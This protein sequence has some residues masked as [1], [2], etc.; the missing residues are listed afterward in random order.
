[1]HDS[2]S[3]VPG[4]D[5]RPRCLV[6]IR[7]DL[8]DCTRAADSW[9]KAPAD[10]APVTRVTPR[11]A[12]AASRAHAGNQPRAAVSTTGQAARRGLA[13]PT[14]PLEDARA[15]GQ[16]ILRDG[17]RAGDVRQRVRALVT[18]TGPQHAGL[19]RHD[20]MQ[21]GRTRASREVARPRVSR[22]PDLAAGLPPVRGDRIP[23]PPVLL[24]LVIHGLEAMRAVADR[25]RA[26]LIRSGTPAPP[27]IVVAVRDAGSGLDAQTVDRICDAFLTT[28]P[29]GLGLGL[30]IRRTMLEAHGGRLWATLHDGPGATVQLTL[31]MHGDRAS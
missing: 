10:L 20:V 21:A 15:A 3:V 26:R 14:P 6:E 18:H 22:R 11:G 5:R 12:W 17:H 25:S 8:T 19:D 1:V 24:N 30:S 29:E 2:G 27:R 23:W 31:P 9:R 4:S 13:A 16:R 28:T 7:D